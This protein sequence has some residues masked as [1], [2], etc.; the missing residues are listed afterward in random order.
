M[1]MYAR[2]RSAFV[3]SRAWQTE[4]IF[5]API[6]ALVVY[7]FYT[8]FAVRDRYF[9]FL[10]FHDMGPGFDTTPFGPVTASRYWMSGLVAAGAVMVLYVAA[11]LVAGRVA[12]GYRAP[13]WWRLWILCA[14]P[15]AIAIPLIVMTVNV[16][17]L[18]LLNALQVTA[19]LL[20]GLAP[21]L[22]L[23]RYA[24]NR[25]VG[26]IVL[27]IDGVALAC[28]MISLGAVE[29]FQRSPGPGRMWVVYVVLAAFIA[30]VGLAT[31]LTMLYI[32][33]RRAEIPD[34]LSWLV[35]GIDVRY[36]FLPLVHYLFF[37]EDDGSWTDPDYFSYISDAANYFQRSLLLQVGIWIVVALVAVGMTRLRTGLRRRRVMR[38]LP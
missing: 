35:A 3:V 23:G 17:V 7:L 18:P 31:T 30:G 6:V 16:P 20:V 14:V 34:A 2:Q 11:N 27:M 33:W 29:S 1:L 26:Y 38:S 9:I 15:L 22:A 24:A 37:C 21:A 10:Y 8:W 13:I 36:L 12:K 4:L 5:A 28:L 19:A 32:W 25:P